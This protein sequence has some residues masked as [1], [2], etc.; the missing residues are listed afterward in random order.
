MVPENRF[1]TEQEAFWAGEFGNEYVSRNQGQ[2]LV[3]GNLA[4]FS[5]ILS[6]SERV[7][8]VIEFGA[9][10]GLNL[11]ALKQL[12]PDAEFSAI[13]IN[14]NASSELE[15]LGYVKVYRQ[16]ILEFESK[17]NYDLALIKGVLIHIHPDMLPEVYDRLYQ[18]SARYICL[19]EYYNPTPVSVPYRGHSERL[20][21]RDFAG[22]ML[23]RFPDL[24]LAS[25]GFSYHR[26]R[27]FPQDDLTWFLLE[28]K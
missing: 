17:E 16:S 3:A 22:E 24:K 2:R 27:N 8:S 5:K 19:V 15:K 11:I 1:K 20:Y 9:N 12:L 13:E 23:D 21:K 6:A 10:V 4:L 7:G 14:A 25:Y 28:K 26:D 18:A